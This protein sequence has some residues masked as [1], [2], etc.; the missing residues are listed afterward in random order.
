[1][2]LMTI[3]CCWLV[4]HTSVGFQLIVDEAPVTESTEKVVGP[5]KRHHQDGARND[6]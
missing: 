3:C 1:M 5:T 2:Y 4:R 6:I